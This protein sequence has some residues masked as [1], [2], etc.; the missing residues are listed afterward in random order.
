[1]VNAPLTSALFIPQ[2]FRQ[3]ALARYAEDIAF[4]AR[5]IASFASYRALEVGWGKGCAH[6]AL[7]HYLLST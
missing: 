3:L 5:I 2:L 1:M 4:A 6:S 7:P